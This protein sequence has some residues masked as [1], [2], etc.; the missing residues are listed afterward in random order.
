MSKEEK[1]KVY[2]KYS[3][4]GNCQLEAPAL[5]PEVQSALQENVFKRDMAIVASQNKIGA[6]VAA[7]G[8]AL[9]DLMNAKEGELNKHVFL[10]K[11]VDTIKILADLHHKDSST[12]KVLINPSMDPSIRSVLEKTK[13]DSFLYGGDL[14][15]KLEEAKAI[16]K[17]GNDLKFHQKPNGKGTTRNDHLNSK[18][19]TQNQQAAQRSSMKSGPQ[20]KDKQNQRSKASSDRS[21]SRYRPNTNGKN[22]RNESY[23]RRR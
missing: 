17:T 6:A 2:T 23:S 19:S 3:L 4:K 15:K 9:T 16:K 22:Q 7:A 1:E 13:T 20:K 12:R 18:G 21:R 10:E 11:L 8:G 5:N 14:A